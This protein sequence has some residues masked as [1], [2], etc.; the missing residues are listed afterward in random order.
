MKIRA[1]ETIRIEERP[2]LVW[3]EVDPA[4]RLRQRGRFQ[5]FGDGGKQGVSDH[6]VRRS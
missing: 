6:W 2:N 4:R 3:I 5:R 1:I